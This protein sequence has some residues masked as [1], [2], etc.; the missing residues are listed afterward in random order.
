VAPDFGIAGALEVVSAVKEAWPTLQDFQFSGFCSTA[1]LSLIDGCVFAI[2][3][4]INPLNTA[5]R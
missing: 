4:A 5:A 1:R 2:A 3:E